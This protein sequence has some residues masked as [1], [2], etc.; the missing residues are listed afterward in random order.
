MPRLSL[1]GGALAPLR[2]KAETQ[3]STDFTNQWAG[4][5]AAF[6]ASCRRASSRASSPS[7]RCPWLAPR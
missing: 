4:Q 1:A 3:G 6:R 5:A 7:R 2:A